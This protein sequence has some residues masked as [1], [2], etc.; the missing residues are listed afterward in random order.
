MCILLYIF[1]GAPT[2]KFCPTGQRIIRFCIA[3][4]KYKWLSHIRC[5]VLRLSR[6]TKVLYSSLK[7]CFCSS[8]VN[9]R[10]EKSPVT[11]N[12]T[13]QKMEH[14]SST[15]PQKKLRRSY[16]FALLLIAALALLS[17]LFLQYITNTQQDDL[18]VVNLASRQVALSQSITKTALQLKDLLGLSEYNF[19]LEELENTLSTWERTHN[20]LINGDP[21]MKLPG[22]NS[23]E[24]RLMFQELQPFYDIILECGQKIV[25]TDAMEIDQQKRVL[26]SSIKQLQS[27]ELAFKEIMNQISF[28]YESEAEGRLSLLIKIQWLILGLQL[29]LLLL[30]G[31]FLFRPVVKKLAKYVTALREQHEELEELNQEIMASQEELKQNSEELTS[32][33]E[34]LVTTKLELEAVLK[35]EQDALQLSESSRAEL[36]ATYEELSHKSKQLAASINY[37]ERIQQSLLPSSEK[38]LKL[39]P[40]SFILFKPRDVVSGDFYW[41]IEKNYKLILAAVD[42]MGHGVP[43]AFMSLIA[44]RLLYE[45]VYIHGITE[46]DEILNMLNKRFRNTL[47]QEQ[48]YNTDSIDMSVCVIDT[49]PTRLKTLNKPASLKYAGARNPLIYIKNNEVFE[50]R[51]DKS[52]VGGRVQNEGYQFTKHEIIIDQ[53]TLFYI[54]SDGYQDQFG[55]P[56]GRKFMK[57]KFK[58][59]LQNNHQCSMQEQQKAL[60]AAFLE[61]RKNSNG[62]LHIQIDDVLVMGFKLL[63]LKVPK[64]ESSFSIR[65]EAL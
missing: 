45:I 50:I 47:T 3:V 37:A 39:L 14:S 24:I 52:S 20:G 16:I 49:N 55:G 9:K 44:E 43:G 62:D 27:S 40:E 29:L 48:N 61:W 22:N 28:Q 64:E 38:L 10:S 5:N 46:P 11:S 32:I 65:H 36:Q 4:R 8:A 31:Y 2:N 21:V 53:P 30:I 33:N 35:N 7:Y 13:E 12:S 26:N 56:K 6:L 54:F 34:H 58:E 1:V 63:P 15:T 42:C 18:R 57:S 23:E 51:G 59:L 41:Y 60:D 17:Q 25:S 19:Q